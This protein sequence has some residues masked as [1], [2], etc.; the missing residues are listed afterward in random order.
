MRR[1]LPLVLCLWLLAGCGPSQ[2]KEAP[3]PA[4]ESAPTT[5]PAPHETTAT[6]PSVPAKVPAIARATA[7]DGSGTGST[8]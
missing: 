1:S 4:A 2:P 6:I 7:S 8:S 5:P 3:T